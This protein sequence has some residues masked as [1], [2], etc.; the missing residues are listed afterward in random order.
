MIKKAKGSKSEEKFTNFLSDYF[1]SQG[2]KAKIK[3]IEV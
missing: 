2:C 1:Q 3:L